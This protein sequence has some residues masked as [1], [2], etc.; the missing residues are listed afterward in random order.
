MATYGGKRMMALQKRIKA[1]FTKENWMELEI[2]TGT[3]ERISRYPRLL[4]SL[5]FGDEDYGG[6]VYEVLRILHDAVGLDTVEEYV[7]EHYP[8]DDTDTTY[9]STKPAT[10][11]LTF[12]PHV[13]KVPKNV[14]VE[15]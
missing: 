12:A 8:D 3:A 11:K 4:R 6:I 9:V 5:D 7:N 13:F 1:S 2:I 10:H 15:P 14:K